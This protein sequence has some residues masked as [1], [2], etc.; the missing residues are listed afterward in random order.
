MEH[1]VIDK[2]VADH[3]I[4]G[5]GCDS[6]VLTES[7]GLSVKQERMPSG[8]KEQLHFHVLAQQFFYVL[9]GCATFYIDREPYFVS[10]LQGI[11]ISPSVNHYIA[12]ETTTD[13]E[14]L[15]ISQPSTMGVRVNVQ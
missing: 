11:A 15:V 14:F 10:A 3:Y 12:N 1:K 6:W 9:T 4:W 5:A 7:A 8:T 13:I 2:Q